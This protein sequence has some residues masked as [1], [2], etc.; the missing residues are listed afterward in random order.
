MNIPLTDSSAF[1]LTAIRLR[2]LCRAQSSLNLDG[3][4][5]G[6]NLRG[7]LVNIMRRAACGGDIHDPAHIASCPICWLVA[8][9]EHPGEERRGY[10]IT[11]PL[12]EMRQYKAGEIFSFYITLF[13]S[14][15]RYLPYFV[16]AVPEVGREGAGVGRGRFALEQI[17]AEHPLVGC[18]EVLKKGEKV[19]KPPVTLIS[20]A[21]ILHLSQE[22]TNRLTAKQPRL[23]LDFKT[24]LRLIWDDRLIKSPDFGVI[25][26]HIL[27]R[28]DDLNI[29]YSTGLPRFPDERQRLWNLANSVRM[30]ESQITWIDVRSGSSRTGQPTWISGL[31]GRACYSASMETWQEL[32]PWL[33]WGQIVQVG[34][35]VVKGNGFFLI[36]KE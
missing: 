30:V 36:D 9:N 33:V 31:V 19:V 25:F 35:D 23:C 1:P 24:P 2:F 22:I 11:P 16:L 20:H 27:K 7:A 34:K 5:A 17:D 18:S 29:Q 15:I 4:R 6:S 14:A 28:L 8:A 26:V 21:D 32:M 3:L 13:G 10:V 12:D